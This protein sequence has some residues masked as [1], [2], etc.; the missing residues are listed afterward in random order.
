MQE[1]II[2][3]HIALNNFNQTLKMRI[4]EDSFKSR[5]LRFNKN[6]IRFSFAHLKKKQVLFFSAKKI[7]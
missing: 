6:Q 5:K 2:F 3:S 1:V 4:H 7:L